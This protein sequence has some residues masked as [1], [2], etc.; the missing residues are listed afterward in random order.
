[1]TDGHAAKTVGQGRHV[2]RGQLHVAGIHTR[3]VVVAKA[4]LA[5]TANAVVLR[6]KHAAD[7][8]RTGA[9]HL[10]VTR[11]EVDVVNLEREV[12]AR[13][14]ANHTG[15]QRQ[16]SLAG[17]K[18][19]VN[20]AGGRIQTT[21]GALAAD[22][23]QVIKLAQHNVAVS[24]STRCA[25]VNHGEGRQLGVQRAVN[26]T[27]GDVERG[28]GGHQLGVEGGHIQHTRHVQC[29]VGLTPAGGRICRRETGLEHGLGGRV[30][31]HHA[32][33]AVVEIDR[34]H[35]ATGR[36]HHQLMV[37]ELQRRSRCGV[38]AEVVEHQAVIAVTRI[39]FGVAGQ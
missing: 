33:K 35:L 18:L 15:R 32:L 3:R 26:A 21:V 7:D 24:C 29:Q 30:V 14:R 37:I 27:G 20:L 6:I 10:V 4:R 39:H 22:N 28:I 11:G 17:C 13:T 5:S 23:T 34:A 38:R 25:A 8:Q 36:S 16:L 19:Q 9:K 1:M 31:K 2:A 12:T